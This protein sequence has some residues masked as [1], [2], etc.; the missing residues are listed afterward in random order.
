[1][2]RFWIR[3]NARLA[4]DA[5]VRAFAKVI[6]PRSS[7]RLG[8]A[9]ACGYLVTLWG[10]VIDEQE[11]GN[12][13]TRDDDVIEEWAKWD[14]KR[15]V[16][17]SAFRSAFT[18]D[19]KIREWDD[20]QGALIER[21]EKDRT[22]KRGKKSAGIPQETPPE[23]APIPQEIPQSSSRNVNGNGNDSSSSALAADVVRLLEALPDDVAQM[24]WG[25]EIA[26]ARQGMHGK[27]L[28]DEQI[29]RAC[30]DY[31]GNGH[32]G[33][34]SLRHFRGFLASAGRPSRAIVTASQSDAADAA[35]DAVL[36]MLPAWQRREI[37]AEAHA[38][39]PA[40]TR[41]GLSK[42]GGFLAIQNT[43]QDKR[44]WLRKDF[45]DGYRSHVEPT[46][47]PA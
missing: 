14:G 40:A 25:S 17:A 12:L 34:P 11:D 36:S 6:L 33:S 22:R 38:N 19:G 39:L 35:W 9:A 47:Q 7:V 1:V 2:T 30:R 21:R 41:R 4:D 3:V 13:A 5:E 44:T 20:Y 46:G 18:T 15:G 16:F 31:V 29:A 24:A 37:T 10:R 32:M 23:S 42:I 26:A 27:P 8:I 28:T 45:C 43:P